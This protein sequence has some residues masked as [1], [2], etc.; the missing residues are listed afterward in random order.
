MCPLADNT[1]ILVLV[2]EFSLLH[3]CFQITIHYKEYTQTPFVVTQILKMRL[4]GNL[5]GCLLSLCLS[6]V[7]G[8]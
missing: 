7:S 3:S 2:S 1:V 5:C 8:N 6:P 4:C